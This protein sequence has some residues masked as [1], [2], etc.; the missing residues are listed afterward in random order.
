MEGVAKPQCFI[1]GTGRC[2]S[3]VLSR[4]LMRHPD[5]LV[6]REFFSTLDARRFA[7]GPVDAPTLASILSADRHPVLPFLQRGGTMP[8][9]LYRLSEAQ[10]REPGLQVPGLQLVALPYLTDDPA[11]LYAETIEWA[12][13]QPSRRLAEHYP[14]LFGFLRAQ[15]GRR[16]AIEA[17]ATNNV[18]LEVFPYCRVLHVHRSGP[19]V[20]LSMAQH[21]FFRLMAAL[22]LDPLTAE[23]WAVV[24]ARLARDEDDPLVA[25]MAVRPSPRLDTFLAHTWTTAVARNVRMLGRLPREHVLELAFEDLLASPE[26]TLQRVA[27]FFG[28]SPDPVWA[29]DV[30]TMLRPVEL[31]LP[32]LEPD[33]QRELAR[34]CAVGQ[35]L[36]GREQRERLDLLG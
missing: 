9:I 3:T 7:A 33:R 12:R 1:T 35:I 17:S 8:E 32:G 16:V 27:E 20:V 21:P 25:R 2:G 34:L 15:T 4:M 13:S 14:A 29:R 31:R 11:R 6:L 30:A 36:T 23:Q 18:D 19:E 22:A 28:L 26:A 5:A 10:R 24:R